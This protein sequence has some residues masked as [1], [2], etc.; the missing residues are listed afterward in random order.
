MFNWTKG[1][2]HLSWRTPWK[3]TVQMLVRMWTTNI[4]SHLDCYLMKAVATERKG[5]FPSGF[6]TV[7]IHACLTS[8]L[9][10][11]TGNAR[12]GQ[13]ST[14]NNTVCPLLCPCKLPSSAISYILRTRCKF[15]W[16]EIMQK[17]VS[18]IGLHFF[19]FRSEIRPTE[20]LQTK[21]I[22][23]EISK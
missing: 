1:K 6:R 5:G 16:N 4:I 18:S 21:F 2:L 14:S 3:R 20:R 15:S 9:I 13:V 22:T 11:A 8:H 17:G 10:S 19:I 12:C 7:S 23:D